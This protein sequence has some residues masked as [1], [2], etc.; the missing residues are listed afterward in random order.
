MA[1]EFHCHA[2]GKLVRAPDDA[3]GKHAKCPA[4]HQSVYVPLPATELDPLPLA[5]V[6]ES[7][8][9]EKE[10]LMRETR[11]LQHRLLHER[12][13]PAD[14]VRPPSPAAG[15]SE[16]FPQ[17]IDIET[18]VI[19]YA[20]C[21]ADGNLEEANELAALI[22]KNR[23]AADDYIQRLMV[24]EILPPQLSRI[25]RPVLMG[26]FKQLREKK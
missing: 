3:G 25:P 9:R 17:A 8:E 14:A 22:R 26:F 19:E 23:K 12:D 5:P 4:C 6:D 7:F 2:C 18:V 1:I 21:M 13:L 16:A 10:R 24:D 20:I 15:A 11:D